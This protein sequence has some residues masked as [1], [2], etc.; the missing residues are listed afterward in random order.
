MTTKQTLYWDPRSSTLE[1]IGRFGCVTGL[2]SSGLCRVEYLHPSF[3]IL[4]L[5]VSRQTTHSSNAVYPTKYV[6]LVCGV[7]NGDGN[8]HL[9]LYIVIPYVRLPEHG[10]ILLLRLFR[11]FNSSFES[12]WRLKSYLASLKHQIGVV[13]EI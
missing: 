2:W 9:F 6:P 3:V 11:L 10:A 13:V 1:S 7:D 12:P 5:H 8:G 4:H